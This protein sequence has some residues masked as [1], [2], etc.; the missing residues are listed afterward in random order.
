MSQFNFGKQNKKQ[1]PFGIFLAS[2]IGAFTF[3]AIFAGFYSDWQWFKVLGQT[4]VYSKQLILKVILFFA[5]GAVAGFILWLSATLAYRVRPMQVPQT[6][7]DFALA[8][9]R[10]ALD[11]KSVV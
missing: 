5:V 2:A 9:Y 4:D 6:P 10:E 11:R 1:S 3:F 8:R 7:A